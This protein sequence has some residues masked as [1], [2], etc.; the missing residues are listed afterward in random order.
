MEVM[1]GL[2]FQ[3]FGFTWKTISAVSGACF[4]LDKLFLLALSKL[5][6]A[7]RVKY[8]VSQ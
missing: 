5:S 3:V 8:Y 4:I 1:V 2:D 6:I 7:V